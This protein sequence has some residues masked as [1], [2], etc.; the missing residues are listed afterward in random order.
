MVKKNDKKKKLL[1]LDE[2][3]FFWKTLPVSV[4]FDKPCTVWDMKAVIDPIVEK[5]V[6]NNAEKL[7]YHMEN[8]YIN[9]EE[10]DYYVG[11]TGEVKFVLQVV[12]MWRDKRYDTKAV[13]WETIEA[14]HMYPACF[15]TLH[16][17]K[18]S[19]KKHS[20]TILSLGQYYTKRIVFENGVYKDTEVLDLWRQVLKDVYGENNIADFFDASSELIESNSYAKNLVEQSVQ[21]YV[22]MLLRRLRTYATKGDIFLVS[23]LINNEYFMK[24]FN[25]QYQHYSLSFVVPLMHMKWLK[26]YGRNWLS[27]DIDVQT[28][29]HYFI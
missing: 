11:K 25:K 6:P 27:D 16:H 15:F 29:A 28:A 10:S 26:T 7:F 1:L 19:L 2:D 3:K 18:N 17:I 5:V 13:L 24:E 4:H 12:A 22:D 8:I 23:S 14:V 21:F 20:G 9:G